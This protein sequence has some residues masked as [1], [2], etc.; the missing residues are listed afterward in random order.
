MLLQAHLEFE[1]VTPRT[2]PDY[3]GEMLLLPGVTIISEAEKKALESYVA[4][5]GKLVI[6]G[7]NATGLPPSPKV[8]QFSDNPAKKYFEEL[9]KD[10]SAGLEHMPQGFLDAVK[11]QS[12]L[13]VSAPP[14]VAVN[15]ASVAGA[16]HAYLANFAGLGPG[17]TAIPSSAKDIRVRISAR[18]GDALQF[19]P[20]LGEPQILHGVR[21]GAEVEFALPEV[22]RGAV[23]SIAAE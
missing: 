16:P 18:L 1:I 2:L 8:V 3:R 11:V 4:H 23:V 19:L 15:F 21:H 5:K 13:E 12:E 9:E 10:F 6:A 14:T 17:G 20:F 7:T 22:G